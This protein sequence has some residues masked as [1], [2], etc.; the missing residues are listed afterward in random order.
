MANR[1]TGRMSLAEKVA[2]RYDRRGP[3]ECWPWL[4]QRNKAGY[5]VVTYTSDFKRPA[6]MGAHRAVWTVLN[7]PIPAGKILLHRCDNPGCVNPR[8]LRPVTYRENAEDALLRDRRAKRYAPHTRTK[9]LTDSQVRAIRLSK[10][11]LETVAH[12]FAVAPTTVSNIRRRLR[13]QLVPDI[14]DPVEASLEAET[15]R[16]EMAKLRAGEVD[17]RRAARGMTPLLR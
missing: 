6:C 3:D 5:G 17:A 9:K 12:L 16:A 2:N 1:Y 13:K 4:G 10:E 7:G 8:H 14:A 15:V 11:P